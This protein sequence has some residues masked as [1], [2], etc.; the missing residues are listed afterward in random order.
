LILAPC[1]VLERCYSGRVVLHMYAGLEIF[2]ATKV[3]AFMPRSVKS[4]FYCFYSY[5]CNFFNKDSEKIMV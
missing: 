3:G 5:K 4:E 1:N 2:G